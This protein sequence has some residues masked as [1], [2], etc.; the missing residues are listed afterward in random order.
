LLLEM[1]VAGGIYKFRQLMRAFALGHGC[2]NDY[3]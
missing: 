1:P 2:K 3:H